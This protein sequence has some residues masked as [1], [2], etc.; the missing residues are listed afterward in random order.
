MSDEVIAVLAASAPRRAFACGVLGVLGV[1]LI[2]LASLTLAATI[3]AVVLFAA[4]IGVMW[5]AWWQYQVTSNVLELTETE[6]RTEGGFILAKVDDVVSVERGA[7]AFKPSQGF[8]LRT[9]TAAERAWAPG[10][11]WRFGKSVGVGGVTSAGQ[12]K[13]MAEMLQQMVVAREDG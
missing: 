12:G 4:G 2:W 13:F 8:L 10:L 6:L 9:R 1:M 11:Y 5:M 3:W 7:L